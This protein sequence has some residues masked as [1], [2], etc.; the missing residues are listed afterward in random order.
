[1]LSESKFF[2]ISVKSTD[3]SK[4]VE[5][6]ITSMNNIF[7]QMCPL[8]KNFNNHCCQTTVKTIIEWLSVV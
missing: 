8:K 7:K 2:K 6:R 3:L 5:L 4:L 1:M